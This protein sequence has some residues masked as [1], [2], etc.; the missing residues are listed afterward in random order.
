MQRFSLLLALLLALLTPA[1]V[2]AQD[3]AFSREVVCTETA[4]AETMYLSQVIPLV[5][6][7]SQQSNDH[8][9]V[10]YTTEVEVF[11]EE[12][13]Q[14][15]IGGPDGQPFWT[16]DLLRIVGQPAQAEWSHDFRS[17]DRMR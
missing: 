8:A 11:M 6:A 7:I 5:D 3:N 2:R 13:M 12:G 15:A 4:E 9:G 17:A 14:A 10:F 16:D 1:L